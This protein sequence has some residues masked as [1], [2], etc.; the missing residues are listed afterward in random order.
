M[1][2][3]NYR[4]TILDE[5]QGFMLTDILI[6]KYNVQKTYSQNTKESI[7]KYKKENK[8]SPGSTEKK[9]PSSTSTPDIFSPSEKDKLFWCFFVLANGFE[10]YELSKK[11]SFKCEKE[12]KIL[13]VEKLGNIKDKLKELKLKKTEIQD[14]LVN[15]HTIGIKGLYA[16]CLVNNINVLYVKDRLLYELNSG[17]DSEFKVIVN[18]NNNIFIPYKLDEAKVSFYRENYWK[19]E[20]IQKPLNAFSGY[21]LG[22]LQTICKKLNIPLQNESKNKTKKE[23]YENILTKL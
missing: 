17:S 22:D 14:E 19:I 16:L 21:S 4:S 18:E 5:L 7:I 15:Q 3:S 1:S 2:L 12:S 9:T 8:L 20:N 11:S 23:L 6:N 13:S 10:E